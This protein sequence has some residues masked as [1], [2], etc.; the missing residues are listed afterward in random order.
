VKVE[1]YLG[2]V[3]ASGEI[4]E[5]EATRMRPIGPD[6]EGYYLFEAA[7]VPCHKSGL[8]GFTVRVLP[9]HPDLLT[10]FLPGLIAWAGPDVTVR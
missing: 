7:A 1:I 10:P 8:H 2:R 5:A 6:G 3:D 9:H 4:L